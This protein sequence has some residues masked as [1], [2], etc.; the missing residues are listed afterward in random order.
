[1][2]EINW[3]INYD[4][5]NLDPEVG[6]IVMCHYSDGIDYSVQ[7]TV[8][9]VSGDEISG[10]VAGVFDLSDEYVIIKNHIL[11]G[12]ILAVPRRVIQKVIKK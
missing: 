10:L 1:M 11:T 4:W 6:D 8:S 3:H 7:L 9:E 5:K 2:E 12:Q